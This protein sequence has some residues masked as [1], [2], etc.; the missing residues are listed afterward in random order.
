MSGALGTLVS[1]LKETVTRWNE[2]KASALAAALAYYA[3]YP[4][5]RWSLSRWRS[6]AWRSASG[7]PRASC[8]RS[9]PGSWATPVLG[10]SSKS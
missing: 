5:L 8:T 3:L 6:P 4:W 10:R 9:S 1:L 7:L 2:D